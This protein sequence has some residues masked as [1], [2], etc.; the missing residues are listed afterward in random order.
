MTCSAELRQDQILKDEDQRAETQ[1]EADLS[2]E[3]E[4]LLGGGVSHG[5]LWNSTDQAYATS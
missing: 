5:V 1:N 4:S 2:R 3:D